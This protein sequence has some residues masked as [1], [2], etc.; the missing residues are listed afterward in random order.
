MLVN[1]ISLNS[2]YQ[3]NY[4]NM[5]RY[6]FITAISLLKVRVQFDAQK[7]FKALLITKT[8]GWHE[9]IND[10]WSDQACLGNLN[11]LCAMAGCW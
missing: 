10:E 5:N 7:Q 4:D 2:V 3:L 1:N 8:A 11:F 6:F 9:S